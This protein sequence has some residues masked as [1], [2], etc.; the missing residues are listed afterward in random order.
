MASGSAGDLLGTLIFLNFFFIAG[1][2]FFA[3]GALRQRK[4]EREQG[5]IGARGVGG[6]GLQ[7]QQ[8]FFFAKQEGG[9]EDDEHRV[10][11]LL[12]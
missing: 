4:A 2:I 5:F 3:P 11:T 10:K 9:G 12:Q 6:G 1:S 8:V 7:Q